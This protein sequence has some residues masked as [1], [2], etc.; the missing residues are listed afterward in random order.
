MNIPAIR[1]FQ[2]CGPKIG[3]FGPKNS[4]KPPKLGPKVRPSEPSPIFWKQK[5]Q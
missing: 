3:H 4:P 5:C 2:N 1:E